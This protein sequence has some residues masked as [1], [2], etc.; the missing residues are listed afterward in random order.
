M[1]GIVWKGQRLAPTDALDAAA[2]SET[3]LPY[4]GIGTELR[5]AREAVMQSVD[6]V[7]SVLRI[8]RPHIQ[9]I[10]DGRFDDLPGQVYAVGFVRAYA[11]HLRLDA[12]QVVERFHQE[13][14]GPS[15][16]FELHFPEPAAKRAR[17]DM[18]A[19]LIGLI[20]AVGAYGA[21]NYLQTRGQLP[22][23]LL[24]TMP[25]DLLF[26]T[27]SRPD[28]ASVAAPVAGAPGDP[29]SAS[30]SYSAGLRPVPGPLSES[31]IEAREAPAEIR[32][33]GTDE[34][35]ADQAPLIGAPT[36]RVVTAVRG[37]DGREEANAAR[38]STEVMVPQPNS[39]PAPDIGE[40]GEETG[41]APAVDIA[42]P[43][44]NLLAA[45]DSESQV[46]P[47]SETVAVYR[48]GESTDAE[49]GSAT[50]ITG[51]LAETPDAPTLLEAELPQVP[52]VPAADYEP[53]IYGQGNTDARIVVRAR[54]ES[55]VQVEG[56][57]NELL[58][59][60]VLNPGDMFLVPNRN[61]LS[62]VTGNA[63]GIEILVDG[64]LMPPLGPVG[65]V[66]RNVK[67]TPYALTGSDTVSS[68]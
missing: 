26:E 49:F 27:E 8:R 18:R 39:E 34:P 21:W 38:L 13:A 51:A 2:D 29:V 28:N 30:G 55:W 62:L 64:V 40:S 37:A 25:P 31:A 53:R 12:D 67:L 16:K 5:A 63:G 24:A 50:P 6:H 65:T 11:E 68:R 41:D 66:R 4:Q 44:E 58:L 17:L 32:R 59:T 15:A 14:D 46:P 33:V 20:I 52:A 60:R 57:N 61:D 23:E 43:E 36:S 1:F 54:V 56:S 19:L 7:A 9:A 3:P 45:L 42:D 10:E 48:L 35:P 47:V 22:R